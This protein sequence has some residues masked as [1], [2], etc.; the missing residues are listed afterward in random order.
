M[1]VLKQHLLESKNSSLALKVL[2]KR[3]GNKNKIE[4]NKKNPWLC[5]ALSSLKAA[6]RSVKKHT[7]K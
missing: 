5:V 6:V 1:S 3:Q 7:K 2:E 4:Q